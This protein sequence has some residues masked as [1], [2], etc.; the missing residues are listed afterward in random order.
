MATPAFRRTLIVG[1]GGAGRLAATTVKAKFL[2][3]YGVMPPCIKIF[4][5]D[6]D[7]A[8][9][10]V[11]SA[12]SQQEYELDPPDEFKY[13]SVPQAASFIETSD[14]V[15]EWY[16]HPITAGA[17][18]HG[19]GAVRQN[20]RVALFY[21][22]QDIRTQLSNIW[23]DL[24]AASLPTAME[25]LR[26]KAGTPQPFELL[27]GPAQ[28]YVCG[29][30]A[31]GTGSGTFIDV[32]IL[33]R[34]MAERAIIQGFFLLNWVYR[35]KP[36]AFR[37]RGNAYA[38]LSELD[39]LQGLEVRDG[40]A[41]STQQRYTVTYAGTKVTVTQPPYSLFHIV[42]GR[43]ENGQVV[44]DVEAL[45]DSVAKAVFLSSS[46]MGEAVMSPVDNLM[47]VVH[48]G[49][50][51]IWNGR[52]ARYSSFGLSSLYY[53]AIELHRLVSTVAAHKLCQ[54]A[55]ADVLGGPKEKDRQAAN[56]E[57]VTPDVSAYLTRLDL[58]PEVLRSRLCPAGGE[59]ELSISKSEIA[60]PDGLA[61]LLAVEQ[62]HQAR[63]LDERI[64]AD[65]QRLV[66]QARQS[67]GQK[68]VDLSATPALGDAY[69][70]QWIGA[71]ASQVEAWSQAA[72]KERV[73]LA[74]S[75]EELRTSCAK[76]QQDAQTCS[77]L[78]GL[79]TSRK[80][81]V[82]SWLTTAMD[83]LRKLREEQSSAALKAFFD[84][85]LTF[86]QGKRPQTGESD[87]EVVLALRR[88]EVRLRD[89]VNV[90]IGNLRLLRDQAGQVLI[91]NG[92]IVVVPGDTI[93]T[94]L[95]DNIPIGFEEFKIACN[96]HTPQDYAANRGQ[97]AESLEALFLKFCRTRF[98][99]LKEI[100]VLEAM[101]AIGD[102]SGDRAGYFTRQ[103]GHLFRLASPLWSYNR[104]Q[105]TAERQAH[106]GRVAILGVEDR[107]TGKNALD[108]FAE[109][110]K[111]KDVLVMN[112]HSYT[113]TGDP[114]HVW[115][116]SFVAPLPMYIIGDMAG[117][118]IRYE[119][120]ITPSYHIDKRLEMDVP[121]LFPSGQFDNVALRVLGMAIVRGIDVI[122]DE[123]LAKGHK[124]T[125]SASELM[126]RN[127]D[128][129]KVW[130]LFRDLYNEVKDD[131]PAQADGLLNTLRGLLKARVGE[132][133]GR[134]AELKTLIEKHIA[135]MR[136]KMQR[137]DFS[138]LVSARLT[139]R[140]I[141]EL[142][143]FIKTKSQGGYDM[144]IDAYLR[145]R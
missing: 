30:V 15:K 13:I 17:I 69:A 91:G 43:K 142:G 2:D 4:C 136:E 31:G 6:T 56:A 49:N 14:A 104:A 119:G 107:Q 128:E 132:F 125:C 21:H 88:C 116:L 29:S 134:R 75:I 144:D 63:L 19:A 33:L 112:D 70:R 90:E 126:A 145:G 54:H 67:L 108:S 73:D 74:A 10:K 53:P 115:L 65:S 86:L 50:E 12:E 85:L 48:A 129:P 61:E 135:Q 106:F 22:I 38:A 124:F 87:N 78:F 3:T 139:Y 62:A 118:K 103:V 121:D 5:L 36:W 60:H 105:L 58:T 25:H 122:H 8:P 42:D 72:A 46:S 143:L 131:M 110:V 47:A 140:E 51:Q 99:H 89:A 114:R 76:K 81:A 7:G 138:K 111:R 127:Y 137:R 18:E 52:H 117:H 97:D 35:N 130:M 141:Q 66:D 98:E 37:V 28:I 68:I 9:V 16:I 34:D 133:A 57:R 94:T 1:L 96:I 109:A 92:E 77:F 82:E 64:Q 26:D 27:D 84:E 55:L 79:G 101:T 83:L 80:A 59:P 45:C 95:S 100:T 39:Y 120:E 44:D 102:Q 11:R 41:G 20:G 24:M 32:G 71:A 123:K 113:T 93:S 23:N 40:Q